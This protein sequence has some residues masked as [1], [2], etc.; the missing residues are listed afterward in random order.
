MFRV[1]AVDHENGDLKRKM[2]SLE[3]S[4][5]SLISQLHSLQSLVGRI[6]KAAVAAS[7]AEARTVLMVSRLRLA[8][9]L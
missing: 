2:E 3:S 7:S 6:P 5:R 9:L 1:A 4:N 8:L